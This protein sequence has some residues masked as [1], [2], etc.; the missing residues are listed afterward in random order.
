MTWAAWAGNAGKVEDAVDACGEALPGVLKVPLN[1]AEPRWGGRRLQDLDPRKMSRK[2]LRA[3]AKAMLPVVQA[4]G[5]EA[6]YGNMTALA[7][8]T[9]LQTF[10]RIVKTI[11][12]Y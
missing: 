12:P 3:V 1:G 10:V 2:E 5:T 8:N 9:F 4:I 6:G 11:G 7:R